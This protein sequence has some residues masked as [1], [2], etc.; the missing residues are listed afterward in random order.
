V[1]PVAS[2]LIPAHWSRI[3]SL[4]QPAVERGG[5]HTQQS[6]LASLLHGGMVL[7]IDSER[8]EDARAVLV[9]AWCDY[10]AGRIGFVLFAGGCEA[11]A[12]TQEAADTLCAWARSWGCKELRLVGRKG[13]GRLLGQVAT[14]Y[15]YTRGL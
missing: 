5:E 6:V 14:D 9:T 8:I 11:K 7:W 4:L 15:T 2:P 10:P 13:W 12:W 1:T 3:W